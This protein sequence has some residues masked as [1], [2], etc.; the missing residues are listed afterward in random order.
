MRST[1][2]AAALIVVCSTPF[3]LH[4]QEQF[5]L[6]ARLSDAEGAP[7][8]TAAPE[9][10]RILEDGTEGKVTKVEAVNWPLKLQILV[11]NGTGLGGENLGQLRNSIR[12]LI[13]DLP[14]TAEVTLVT[15]AP[16]PRFV[17]RATTDRKVQLQGV[18]RIA[19][20]GSTG[21]FVMSLVEA[22]QRI[23][24]D[25]GDYYPVI[26]TVGTTAGDSNPMERDMNNVLRRVQQRPTT[27]HS[28]ILTGGGQTLSGGANQIE[29]GMGLAKVTGGR[30]E[31]IN[32]SSRLAAVLSEIGEQVAKSHGA[33]SGRFRVTVERPG[34]KKGDLGKIGISTRGGVLA[35]DITVEAP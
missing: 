19:P 27:V 13:A 29:M 11:D 6:F 31:N 32:S 1:L 34:G 17:V 30:Y 25:K 35:T 33:E 21:Q 9:N 4:A 15:T 12:G 22:T 8:S 7:V 28:V 2:V 23:E 14:P 18:D 5:Y 26:I 16:Q 24:R 3:A 20:D 10:F